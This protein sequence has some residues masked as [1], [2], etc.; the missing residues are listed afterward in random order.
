MRSLAYAR[1]HGFTFIE[2]LASLLFMAIVIPAVVS[3]LTI[4]NRAAIVAERTSVAVQLGQ[5]HLSEIVIDD[6]WSSAEARGEFGQEWPGYRWEL[7]QSASEVENMTELVLDVFFPAQGKE[8]SIR[9]STLVS[10]S[11]SQ[12]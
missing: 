11:L 1:S 7:T 6:S 10:S 3:A 9:L 8:Q 5:N 2:V 12:Q 4:S